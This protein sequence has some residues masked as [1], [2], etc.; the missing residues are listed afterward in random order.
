MYVRILDPSEFRNKYEE[1]SDDKFNQDVPAGK[2][3]KRSKSMT[4][5]LPTGLRC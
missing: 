2:S 1:E 5:S 3:S 4:P